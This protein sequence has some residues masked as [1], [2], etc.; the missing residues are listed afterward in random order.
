MKFNE[1]I[2]KLVVQYNIYDR[3]N[4][5]LYKDKEV[6]NMLKEL[7]NIDRF[8]FLMKC[9]IISDKLVS[10]ITPYHNTKV[11]VTSK[12]GELIHGVIEHLPTREYNGRTLKN[13]VSFRTYADLS[14]GIALWVNTGNPFTTHLYNAEDIQLEVEENEDDYA[15]TDLSLEDLKNESELNALENQSFES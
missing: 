8:N 15:V 9:N 3:A 2:Q 10:F 13:S 5:M 4:T 14:E 11:F 1:E 6:S 7:H 12:G